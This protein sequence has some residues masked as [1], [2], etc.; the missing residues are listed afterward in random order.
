MPC[1]TPPS[2][3]GARPGR[4]Q[5][6]RRLIPE[7]GR[8]GLPRVLLR[9]P[10][11]AALGVA[12]LAACSA[13]DPGQ[14]GSSGGSGTAGS[15]AAHPATAAGT[16]AGSPRGG[17]AG[18]LTL[19]V[20]PAPYQLPSGVAREVVLPA[21]PDLLLAGGLTPQSTSTAE[22]RRLNPFDGRH[23]AGGAPHRPHP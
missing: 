3:S 2:A 11:A 21:G 15:Q 4:Q 18:P 5:A 6:S 17:S 12:L 8:P 1:A 19:Q 10:V 20:S 13:H 7:P 14:A 22:V 9:R 23:R 16:A